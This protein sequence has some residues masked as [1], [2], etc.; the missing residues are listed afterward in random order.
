MI[1]TLEVKRLLHKGCEA[2]IAHVINTSVSRVNLENVPM[3]YEFSNV[4]LDNLSRLP[5]DKE[6]EFGIEV[7]SGSTPISIPPYRMAPMELNELK[8]QLQ[9]LVDKGFIKLSVSPW[10]ASVLFVKKKSETM[11][12]C[13]DYR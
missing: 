8:I 9:D 3:V 11:R 4:F 2:Y 6:L 10:D 12:L 13:I 1:S 5:P 7:L